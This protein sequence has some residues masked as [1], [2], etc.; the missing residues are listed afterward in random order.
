VR[1]ARSRRGP[2]EREEDGRQ[3]GP[4]RADEVGAD[5]QHLARLERAG[6]T[7]DGERGARLVSVALAVVVRAAMTLSAMRRAAAP[8]S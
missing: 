8:A 5:R 1:A 2:L 6:V 7:V 4:S 3:L